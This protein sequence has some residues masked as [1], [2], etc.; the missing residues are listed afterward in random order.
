[1]VCSA[2]ALGTLPL[3]AQDSWS[4]QRSVMVDDLAM[5]GIDGPAVLD[6]LRT[7]PR[8]EF[9]PED[10]RAAAYDDVPDRIAHGQ[11]VSQPYIVAR[12]TELLELSS[13]EKVLEIGTGSGYHTAILSRIAKEVYS[14]EIR[15]DLAAEARATLA[16]LQYSNVQ[17][18]TA[19]GYNGWPEAAP[20][21]AIVMSAAP[22]KIPDPLMDQLAVGG[23]IV[24]PVG[25]T[26]QDLVVMTKTSQ[27]MKRRRV[28]P[29]RFEE[30]LRGGQSEPPP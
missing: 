12:M 11:T 18:R 24:A 14:I 5:R 6:A 28:E 10:A 13:D 1:M 3:V 2:L 27:G 19:D 17:V 15:P 21:D 22:K 7:V 30:M 8:H 4:E 23:T 16:R 29:V 9:L 26:V 20:F 25:G